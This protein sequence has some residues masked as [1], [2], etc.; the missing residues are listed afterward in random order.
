[1]SFDAQTRSFSG[2]PLNGDV[3]SLE[4]RVTATDLA[5]ASASQIFSLGIAN[6]ND[7]PVVVG[8]LAGLKLKVGNALE[9]RV[10]ADSFADVDAGDSLAYSAMLADGSPLPAWLVMDA[11]T[12][13]L[14][15]TPA[16]SDQ[17]DLRLN[18]VATDSAGASA[19]TSLSLDVA[20]SFPG[21]LRVGT[22]AGEVLVGTEDDDVFDGR[23][24]ADTLIGGAGDDLYLVSDQRDR[25]VEV[26]G[27]GFDTVWADTSYT[28]S[29]ELEALG[30]VGGADHAGTGNG[31]GN[32]LSGNRGDNRLDGKAG[33]DVLLGNAGDDTLIGGAGLDALDG[34]LGEDRIEDGEGAGFIAGG[35]GND[36]IRLASG[37]DVIAFN[38]GDGTD[39]VEG[40]DGQNDTLSL[41]GD[42]RMANLV[43]RKK[44]KDLIVDTGCG[45]G[46]VLVDWYKSAANRSIAVLQLA[47][48]SSAESFVRYDFAGLVNR[49]DAVLAANRRADSWPPAA[50][51]H[52]MRWARQRA[53]WRAGYWRRPMRRK[54]ASMASALSRR[55]A[56]WPS[57]AR[58]RRR[59]PG[60]PRCRCRRNSAGRTT[61]MITAR[62]MVTMTMAATVMTM[63]ADGI[64]CR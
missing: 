63:I 27:G 32:L 46:V 28:L 45:D 6:T 13:R 22:P 9:W 26:T 2:T 37:A 38:R 29:A 12:G 19:S 39:R 36:S 56:P 35:A 52:V 23:C 61:T 24:G 49:F 17:G 60:C 25:I 54:A 42:I 51:R 14:S 8:T 59:S 47:T 4:L 21:Q 50:R 58:M 41:G 3:G 1:L 44:G 34:G 55:A 20:F 43:L 48:T 30:L 40:G 10:P 15:G 33:D 53:M 64:A 11:L 62:I 5:G 16:P 31:L 7:A 57:R 18:I